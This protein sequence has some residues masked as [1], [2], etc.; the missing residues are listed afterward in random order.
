MRRFHIFLTGGK[1]N[2]KFC[3]K[4]WADIFILHISSA[5]LHHD[6][7]FS[8]INKI[9]LIFEDFLCVTPPF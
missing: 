4:D 3:G 7:A 8:L 2:L 5:G 6:Y 9:D 1:H